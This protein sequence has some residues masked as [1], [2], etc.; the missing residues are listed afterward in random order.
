MEEYLTIKENENKKEI[1]F[2]GKV[3]YV[4]FENLKITKK[5]LDHIDLNPWQYET[6]DEAKRI[7]G[8][9]KERIIKGL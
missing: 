5:F 6:L 3:Y 8:I 2:D 7:S 1:W 9:I 4:E